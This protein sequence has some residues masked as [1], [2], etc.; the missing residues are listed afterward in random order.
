MSRWLSGP[1]VAII[2]LAALI[3]L[4]TEQVRADPRDFTLVND[5]RVTITHAYVSPSTT[6]D[7]EEDILGSDV[8]PPGN[9]VEIT[10]SRFN[11]SGEC[12]YDIKVLGRDGSEGFLYKINLCTTSTVTFN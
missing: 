5:S 4:N 12:T 11:D 3:T 6:T 1:L 10:F 2:M 9:S 7:W 8:L